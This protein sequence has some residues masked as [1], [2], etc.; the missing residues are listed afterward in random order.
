MKVLVADDDP[1]VRT[2]LERLLKKFGHE[3][4]V[5]SNGLEAW[6]KLQ[7]EA[8]PRLLILDWMMPE[9]DGIELCRKL[10]DRGDEHYCYVIMLTALQDKEDIVAG[11]EAGADDYMTKPFHLGELR[12]RLKAGQRVIELEERAAEAAKL[13]LVRDLAAGVAHNF[14]NIL[15]TVLGYSHM[16]RT[17]LEKRGEPLK[18]IDRAIRSVHRAARLADQLRSCAEPTAGRRSS[19]ALGAL[20]EKVACDCRDTLPPNIRLEEV[21]ADADSPLSVAPAAVRTALTSI[22]TNAREAMP[23]GG[24]LTVAARKTTRAR[25]G[26]ECEFGQIDITDTGAGMPEDVLPK[27][28]DPFFSTKQTVGVGIGL[29]VSRRIIEDHGGTVEVETEPGEGTRFRILLPV[30]VA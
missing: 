9:L 11:L 17:A 19:M 10:R 29:P 7:D 25:S 2:A 15:A 26:R 4:V 20:V 30:E 5:V 23:D 1:A 18:A 28:F 21:V 12:A 16:A 3:P 6:E 14:N 22:C 8:A 13:G 27:I 24:T